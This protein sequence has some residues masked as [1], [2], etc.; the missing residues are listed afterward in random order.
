MDT[1]GFIDDKSEEA[2]E[3]EEEEEKISMLDIQLELDDLKKRV[4]K[5][6]KKEKKEETEEKVRDSNKTN[7]IRPN[8]ITLFIFQVV[9]PTFINDEVQ[10]VDEVKNINN[11]KN[12][13][14][15]TNIS[16]KFQIK[17]G[18][19][20]CQTRSRSSRTRRPMAKIINSI[21]KH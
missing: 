18:S 7:T 19:R 3:E 17:P 5:L 15:K 6:E 16:F 10:F 8:K 2:E 14:K 13:H 20:Q 12:K 21:T 9:L 11:L 1:S 4:K